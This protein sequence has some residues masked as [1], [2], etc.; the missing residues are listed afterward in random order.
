MIL[1]AI[2]GLLLGAAIGFV[3]SLGSRSLTGGEGACPMTCN[4]YIATVLGAVFGLMMAL[5]GSQR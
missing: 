3:I 2:L 1:K 5:G 4:P